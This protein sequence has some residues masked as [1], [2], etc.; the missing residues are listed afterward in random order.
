MSAPAAEHLAGGEVGRRRRTVARPRTT[1]AWSSFRALAAGHAG[2]ALRIGTPAE[3]L[4]AR[5]LLHGL[6]Y[7]QATDGRWERPED[8]RAVQIGQLLRDRKGE[9]AR[10]L[11]PGP[12]GRAE[13]LGAYRT[14]RCRSRRRSAPSRTLNRASRRRV[15]SRC[16]GVDARRIASTCWR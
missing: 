1:A 15:D 13:F 8:R 7:T 6:G 16:A 9:E 14:R 3:I 10:A 4:E 12:Q 11:L 5:G 2:T